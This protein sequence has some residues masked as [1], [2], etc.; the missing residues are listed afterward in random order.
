MMPVLISGASS[1]DTAV[2]NKILIMSMS[3]AAIDLLISYPLKI[4]CNI[5]RPL[6]VILDIAIFY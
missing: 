1:A 2:Q 5:S 3:T 6:P 4:S